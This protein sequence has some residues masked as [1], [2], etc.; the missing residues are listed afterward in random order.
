MNERLSV[1]GDR[2]N[3]A[4][5]TFPA[6]N[7]LG[8]REEWNITSDEIVSRMRSGK[9]V[10]WNI[11]PMVEILGVLQ[12]ASQEVQ[13]PVSM[14][15][16]REFS[17]PLEIL[18]RRT[19]AGLYSFARYHKERGKKGTIPFLFELT[20]VRATGEDVIAAMKKNRVIHIRW[21]SLPR[22]VIKTL[23]EKV[24]QEQGKTAS[25]LLRDDLLKPSEALGGKNLRRVYIYFQRHPDRNGKNTMIFL[26][27]S[28][29]IP[30]TIYDR[31]NNGMEKFLANVS[32]DEVR[33][34]YAEAGKELGKPPSMLTLADLDNHFGFLN[35]QTLHRRT[36]NADGRAT[37]VSPYK[38]ADIDVTLNDVVEVAKRGNYIPWRRIHMQVIREILANA[39]DEIGI[40]ISM[41]RLDERHF[42]FLGGRS[43]KG[44]RRYA[45]THEER[46]PQETSMR[47]LRR[48]LGLPEIS[49]AA[50][51]MRKTEESFAQHVS[52]EGLSKD[53]SVEALIPWIQ[54]IAKLYEDSFLNIQKEEIESEA[55][56]FISEAI[57]KGL[58]T[59]DIIKNLHEHLEGFRKKESQLHYQ[60]ELL[61]TPIHGGFILQDMIASKD[62][63]LGLEEEG[64]SEGFRESLKVLTP[65]QQQLVIAIAVDGKNLDE[66]TEELGLDRDTLEEHYADSLAL[67]RS[68]MGTGDEA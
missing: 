26:R 42:E 68:I 29:G 35:W 6:A 46:M 37:R 51:R 28:C 62:P 5:S 34:L 1:T 44:L 9:N 11:V 12:K 47:F 21:D 32:Q 56:I 39:A 15:G 3:L 50:F 24:A 55:V 54:S 33:E 40:D 7:D 45:Y 19:L 61:S 31:L 52:L 10:R 59:D 48:K 4:V 16:D 64:L 53:L 57:G 17:Q 13:I 65:F 38:N 23:L 18:N 66:L 14:L 67:L 63:E 36:R 43:L 20:G 58:S 30:I 27:E 22:E 25:S 60:E 2:S 49:R 8:R 41:V